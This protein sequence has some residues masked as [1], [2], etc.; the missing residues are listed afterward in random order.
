MGRD[1]ILT[2]GMADRRAALEAVKLNLAAPSVLENGLERRLAFD[3]CCGITGNPID[4]A[5]GDPLLESLPYSLI[6]PLVVKQAELAALLPQRLAGIFAQE[7]QLDIVTPADDEAAAAF[8]I[9]AIRHPDHGRRAPVAWFFDLLIEVAAEL[10]DGP[11]Q[12]DS[13]NDF[14]EEKKFTGEQP[15]ALP[16]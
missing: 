6:A 2:P 7:L 15:H 1:Y 10:A 12:A 14:G 4:A 16:R 8:Q 5:S 9:A 13:G 11:R 3:E